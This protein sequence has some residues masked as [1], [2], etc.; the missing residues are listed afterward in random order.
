MSKYI[1]SYADGV[2]ILRYQNGTAYQKHVDWIEPSIRSQHDYDSAGQGS[3]R[4]ATLLLYMS[5]LEANQ[6]GETVFTNAWPLDVA[7]TERLTVEQVSIGSAVYSLQ[8]TTNK[9]N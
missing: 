9:T 1:E 8:P 7:E 6:G 5:N 2:Q 3:N 4:F